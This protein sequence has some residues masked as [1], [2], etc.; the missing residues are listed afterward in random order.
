MFYFNKRARIHNKKEQLTVLNKI[1]EKSDCF[2]TNVRQHILNS[3][4]T[5]RLEMTNEKS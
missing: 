2:V 4:E 5:E 3:D 1:E